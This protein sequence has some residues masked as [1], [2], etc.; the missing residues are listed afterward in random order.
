MAWGVGAGGRRRFLGDEVEAAGNI[1]WRGGR[2]GLGR[3]ELLARCCRCGTIELRS[4]QEPKGVLLAL[5]ESSRGG[6]ARSRR[7]V[8]H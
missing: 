3:Y 6:A 2:P 5:K 8:I 1:G 7:F 4:P